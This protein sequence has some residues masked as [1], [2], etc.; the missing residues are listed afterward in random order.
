MLTAW[1][2]VLE[3]LS[4]QQQNLQFG[5]DLAIGYLTQSTIGCIS[6]EGA[7]RLIRTSGLGLIGMSRCTSNCVLK[8]RKL[9]R[10][11]WI[12]KLHL[13]R[14]KDKLGIQL[15]FVLEHPWIGFVSTLGGLLTRLHDLNLLIYIQAYFFLVFNSLLY[16]PL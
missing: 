9:R 3:Q 4:I 13:R 1:Y 2:F 15:R 16:Y 10:R 11:K 8:E 14:S 6:Q 5:L 7:P 12:Q